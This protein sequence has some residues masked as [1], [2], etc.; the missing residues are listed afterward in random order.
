VSA[1]ETPAVVVRWTYY[2]GRGGDLVS[3]MVLTD[4]Q[5]S[6]LQR[7]AAG[8]DKVYLGEV[9]GKHSEV[10][11]TLKPEQ[12]TVLT[13]NPEW[14]SIVQKVIGRGMGLNIYAYV[15]GEVEA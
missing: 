8:G 5:W 12:F 13:D 3:M 1:N 7:A 6:A 9:C 14:A 15:S 2:A 10:T 11:A 4:D